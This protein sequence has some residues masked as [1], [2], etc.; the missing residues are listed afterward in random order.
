[1]LP[2]DVSVRYSEFRPRHSTLLLLL[3]LLLLLPYVMC[4]DY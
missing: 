1:M 2:R 3:L 4:N